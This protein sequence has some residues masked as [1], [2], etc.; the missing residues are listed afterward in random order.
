[1][2]F[3]PLL[4]RRVAVFAGLCVGLS[5]AHAQNHVVT[6]RQALEAAWT[7]SPSSRAAAN[8][9]AELQA[10]SEAARSLLAGSPAL[11]L[12]HRTDRLQTNGGLREYEVEVGLPL[13]NFGMRHATQRQVAA[14]AALQELQIQLARLKLAGELREAASQLATLQAERNLVARKL[15]EANR[16]AIDTERRL[17]AGDTAR[18]D[19]LQAQSAIRQAEGLLSQADA[20]LARARGHWSSLTGLSTSPELGEQPGVATEH[21]ALMVARAQVHSAQMRLALVEADRRDPM[22]LGVGAA[23]ERA[24]AGAIGETTMRF[25]IRIPFGGDTRNAAKLAAARAELDAALAEADATQRQIETEREAARVRLETARRNETL[26]AQRAAL[27]TQIQALI[28]KAHQLGETDLPSRMRADNEKFDAELALTRA[29]I[30]IRR[31]VTQL[32]QSL[33]LLP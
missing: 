29:R 20:A 8:R 23:R 27:A 4:R 12:A 28:A 22:E 1:L 32:N 9:Q 10:K 5:M 33:G 17:K 30:D 25:S 16:L 6:L 13:W 7:L 15:D 3:L 19:L 14:D 21:P 18:V 11:T 31:A 26:A 2:P 24:A